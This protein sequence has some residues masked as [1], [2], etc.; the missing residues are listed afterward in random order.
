M[1]EL[2]L[3]ACAFSRGDGTGVYAAKD[4]DRI[5]VGTFI[6]DLLGGVDGAI[7][8]LV[9]KVAVTRRRA[10]GEED[11]DL[12]GVGAT[13]RKLLISQLQAIVGARGTVRTDRVDRAL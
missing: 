10:I 12:L 11:D 3:S 4:T 6:L 1:H 2:I 8:H 13:K 7:C 5:N 9:L